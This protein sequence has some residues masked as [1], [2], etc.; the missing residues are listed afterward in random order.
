MPAIIGGTPLQREPRE[1]AARIGGLALALEHVDVEAGLV[2]GVRRE[3]LGRAARNRRVAMD[4]L[5]DDAAHHL[6]AERQRHDIEQH[7]LLLAAGEH[8]GLHRGAERDDLV[9]I[10]VA[11]RLLAEQLAHEVAHDRRARRATDEDHAVELVL[12]PARHP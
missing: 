4:Q 9:G 11:Q 5:L 3:R 10:E 1:R 8:V 12:A 7:D 6:D 2:V